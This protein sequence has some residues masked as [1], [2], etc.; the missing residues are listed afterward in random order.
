MAQKTPTTNK[1]KR[2]ERRGEG[3]GGKERQRGWEG[4]REEEIT[5]SANSKWIW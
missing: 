3:R 5:V 4:R 2:K 1:K